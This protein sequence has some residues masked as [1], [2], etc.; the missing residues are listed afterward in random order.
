MKMK[1]ENEGGTTS[2]EHEQQEPSI[3]KMLDRSNIDD[4]KTK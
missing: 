2:V 3:Y 4:D 1:L